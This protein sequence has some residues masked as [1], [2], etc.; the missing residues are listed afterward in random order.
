MESEYYAVSYSTRECAQGSCGQLA[1][2]GS[3][4]ESLLVS[5]TV[6]IYINTVH[7]DVRWSVR[8]S[9]QIPWRIWCLKVPRRSRS[10]CRPA[11]S[12]RIPR[13]FHHSLPRHGPASDVALSAR[14]RVLRRVPRPPRPPRP[15][16]GAGRRPL[17]P[18]SHPL[19]PRALSNPRPH[20][21]HPPR[22]L[23]PEAAPLLPL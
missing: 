4:V 10:S 12:L 5:H 20:H 13:S 19:R 11:F 7:L 16:R 18:G 1:V 2:G 15:H 8:G 21:Q 9:V 14:V 23:P 17:R 22:P 3:L 6:S